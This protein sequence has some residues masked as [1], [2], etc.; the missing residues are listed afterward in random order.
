[1]QSY[2]RRRLSGP[3]AASDPPWYVVDWWLSPFL[4]MLKP[5]EIALI[6]TVP[7]RSPRRIQL[8]VCLF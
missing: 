4:H 1:M 3:L 2:L 5:G 7:C 8:Q 6:R